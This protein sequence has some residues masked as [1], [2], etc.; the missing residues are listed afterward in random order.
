MFS[1]NKHIVRNKHKP[2]A[3]GMQPVYVFQQLTGGYSANIFSSVPLIAAQ[4]HFVFSS[5]YSGSDPNQNFV[6]RGGVQPESRFSADF[7]IK[8]QPSL[9][10][11][12]QML[13]YGSTAHII[14][15]HQFMKRDLLRL[16]QKMDESTSGW[17]RYRGKQVSQ[18]V[19]LAHNTHT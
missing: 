4:P 7:S 1:L 5:T 12:C 3:N 15:C 13:G 17:I 10:K 2:V 16:C 8:H 18:P 9:F 11:D 6:K 14:L 19:V